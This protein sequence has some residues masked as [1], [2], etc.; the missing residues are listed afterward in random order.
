MVNNAIPE[1]TTASTA[2][3]MKALND[4]IAESSKSPLPENTDLNDDDIKQIESTLCCF[5]LAARQVKDG[6]E[7]KANSLKVG[8]FAMNRG[9]KNTYKHDFLVQNGTVSKAL[10]ARMKDPPVY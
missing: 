5:I 8:L 7:Y 3:W 4:Y 10:V 1:N 9:Y 2:Q 6:L